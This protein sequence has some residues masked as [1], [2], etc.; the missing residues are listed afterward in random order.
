MELKQNLYISS[1]DSGVIAKNKLALPIDMRLK[2]DL[3]HLM[4][5]RSQLCGLTFK[6]LLSTKQ[7]WAKWAR[8]RA[9]DVW[10]QLARRKVTITARRENMRWLTNVVQTENACGKMPMSRRMTATCQPT[11]HANDSSTERGRTG[12]LWAQPGQV[13]VGIFRC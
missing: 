6:A 13:P 8:K 10:T 4:K 12:Q 7:T 5:G 2:L 11:S 9:I 3:S 1:I